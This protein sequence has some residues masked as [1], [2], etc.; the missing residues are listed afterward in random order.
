MGIIA[1]SQLRGF[2]FDPKVKLQP[3]LQPPNAWVG[4]HRVLQFPPTSQKQ[5]KGG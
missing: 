4:F 3:K 2:Q 5:E 1:A